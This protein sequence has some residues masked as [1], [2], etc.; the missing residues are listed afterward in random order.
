MEGVQWC[1]VAPSS[2]VTRTRH[3]RSV[4]YIWTT[5]TSSLSG[6]LRSPAIGAVGTLVCG[7]SVPLSQ[8]RSCFG[9]Q[10]PAMVACHV[11]VRELLWSGVCQH[12]HVQ[13][14]RSTS[15]AGVEHTVLVSQMENVSTD[16]HKCLA[17]QVGGGGQ[18]KW[19]SPTP[20]KFLPEKFAVSVCSSITCPKISQQ[21]SFMYAPGTFKLMLGL[22]LG[23]DVGSW[24]QL[25]L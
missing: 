18:E 9:G 16:A 8:G 2:L 7:V 6:Q 17:V 1:S 19:C 10:V 14:G 21:I 4:L 23:L 11:Q 20:S 3:S 22:G 15:D 13:W 25:G 24:A 5:C 12:R